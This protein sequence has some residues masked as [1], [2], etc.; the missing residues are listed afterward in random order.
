M[1]EQQE[2]AGRKGRRRGFTLVELLVVIAVL[3]LLMG[4]LLPVLSKA[5]EQ[6][7]RVHCMSNLKQLT[8]VWK[9]Y[10]ADNKGQLCPPEM[11]LIGIP[12]SNDDSTQERQ[13]ESGALWLYTQDLKVYKCRSDR[14][15][16]LCSYATSCA[17]G[18]EC[19][20][21]LRYFKTLDDLWRPGDKM[22]FIDA[23]GQG[24]AETGFCPIHFVGKTVKWGGACDLM[25][26][27]HSRGCNLSF[28]DN[29][30]EYWKW[31]QKTLKLLSGEISQQQASQ[32]NP[33]LHRMA[34]LLKGRIF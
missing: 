2:T 17:M 21:S 26:A 8:I 20:E 22:V 5:R 14:E 28:A 29:H 34:G 10:A 16:R 32:D 4:I 31:N 1:F 7:N 24:P 33:D 12:D 27:R 25:T 13:I 3:G 9:M 30:C 19:D 15:D 18:G 11:V 23:G 6:G